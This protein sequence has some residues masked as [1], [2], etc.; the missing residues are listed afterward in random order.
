MK[1][2]GIIYK[3][4]HKESGESYIGA[5][6]KT[7]ESRM[8]DHIQKANKGLGGQFQEAIATQGPEAFTWAQI[9]TANSLN[10]L[11]RMEK[12][13][14]IK[15]D[16]ME[17]GFNSDSGGGMQKTV[18]QYTIDGSLVNTF[19]G[20]E[21]ASKEV[22]AHKTCVGN[23]CT[24][25]SKTCKGYHWSYSATFPIGVVDERKKRVVQFDLKNNF[26][27]EYCSVAEASSSSGL[28]K[29]C[30]SRCCRGERK[31]SGG[32]IWKYI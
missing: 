22:G 25:Q 6:T 2:K 18:F 14:I 4:T 8:A 30:I 28:S 10:E 26:V 19:E 21:S 15:Y 23:A 1:T 27:A 7:M 24:G 16:S 31:Q 12:E 13:Y 11:A 29:T 3:V 32:Y 5:T 9:D 17:N 20:L